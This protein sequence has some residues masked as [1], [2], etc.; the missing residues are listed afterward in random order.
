M[1]TQ[2]F[3]PKAQSCNAHCDHHSMPISPT[4]SASGHVHTAMSTDG[5]PVADSPARPS[6]ERAQPAL[7]P[8]GLATRVSPRSSST[9]GRVSLPAV[10]SRATGQGGHT[11]W[12]L[13]DSATFSHG[14][15]EDASKV[16]AFGAAAQQGNAES[17]KFVA[18]NVN[19]NLLSGMLRNA[20]GAATG[21][22]PA[23]LKQNCVY[24]SKAAD[25]NLEALSSGAPTQ[26]W[27]ASETSAGNLP[28]QGKDP[29][30]VTKDASM[31]DLIKQEIAPGRR[32]IISV[33]Q[34]GTAVA[35]HAMNVVRA[36]DGGIHVID[37]Q[38]SKLYDLS[39]QIDQQ[40]F[41]VKFGHNG[42][43]CLA[44][45]FD[46]GKAPNLTATSDR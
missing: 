17:L 9:A 10:S 24:C 40:A 37:G 38:N 44:R 30:S 5:V 34:R 35:N 41:Q 15:K 1:A 11:Q 29:R 21:S 2:P 7:N 18:E 14:I 20:F 6:A 46:T 42:G 25:Q 28:P 3:V 36:E 23:A 33:P 16:A 26:F 39:S 8:H 4:S 45:F 32:G 13:R 27:V 31:E 22:G 19:P 43:P 12:N